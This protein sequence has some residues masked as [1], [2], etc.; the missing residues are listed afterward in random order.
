MRDIADAN[1]IANQDSRIKLPVVKLPTF[2][3]RTEEWKR[4]SETFQSMIH[5][6]ENIP[7]IQKFQYLVTSVSGDAAK[8]IESIEL[9]DQ[10]YT[11]A[12]ELLKRRFDDP[13]AIKKKHIQCLFTMPRIDKE[14]AVAIRGLVDYV[15]KHLRVLKS[16]NLPT[17]SW[18]E[19]VIHMIESKL[20]TT[21]LR[22]WEQHAVIAEVKLATLTDF[23]ERRCQILERLEARTKEKS[24]ATR[25]EPNK[26]RTKAHE[27][28]TTLANVTAAGK[29]YLCHGDHLLYRCEKF[30]ELTVE[31]RIKEVRRLKLCLNC[32]RDDHF[33]KTCK[34]GTCR[35]CS[36][37]HNTLCHQPTIDEKPQAV[38]IVAERTA[39][40]NKDENSSN[41]VVHHAVKE[42]TKR[43]VIMATAVVNATHLNGS[44]VPLR[45]LLDS[46]SEAHFI[47][48]SACN[49]LGLRRERISET[50]TGIGE[51]ESAVSQ[52]C[53]VMI[54]S[55]YSD[56]RVNIRSL[57][58]PKITKF[59]PGVEINRGAFNIPPNIKLADP[60]FYKRG[61]V[62]ML[63]G[64]E[65]F[66]DWLE[67]GKIVL[68]NERLILQ[69]TKLGWIVAGVVADSSTASL[70]DKRA[71]MVA[72]TCS[73]EHCDTLNKTLRRF[74][75]LENC[76]SGTKPQ[77]EE[78]RE[79]D[80]FFER[81]TTRLDNGRFV[82]RLPFRDDPKTLG[83][84]RDI[85]EKRLA[86]LERRFNKNKKFHDRYVE[87][88][89]D[90]LDAGHM[91]PAIGFIQVPERPIVY[92]PHHGVTKETSTTTKLRA[93][94][95]ASS[96]TSSGKSLNDV[97]RVGT[98]SQGSL[99]EILVRF[100]CYNVA[101]IGDIRQMYRQVLV[102]PEDRDFQRILWRFFLDEPVQEF[103]L[104]TVTYGEA[105]SAHLAIRCIQRLAEESEQDF[106]TA[107]RVLREQVYVDDILAG[108]DNIDDAASLQEQLTMI[109]R[110]GGF[111]AHKWCSNRKEAIRKVPPHLKEEAS[112]FRVD[113]DGIIK[114]L[115]LEWN[116][117]DDQF[118]FYMHVETAN[119]KREILSAISKFFDPLGL[120]GPIIIIAKLIMQETWRTRGQ[121]WDEPLSAPLAEKWKAFR[122]DLSAATTI[123][124]PR[125]IIPYN[126]ASQIYLQGF[127]DASQHA[128]GAC[129]YVQAVDRNGT[130]TSRLLCSKSR[131]APIKS[132]S[133]PRLEL[134]SAVLLAHLIDNVQQ[135][136]RVP[137]SGVQAWSDS[138][139]ALYW[140]Y[141]D[142]SRWKPFVANRVTEIVELLPAKHWQHVRGT[143]N[144]ADLISR[145]VTLHQ[146]KDSEIWWSGPSWLREKLPSIVETAPEQEH[147]DQIAE[148]I[149]EEERRRVRT[150]ILANNESSIS[151]EL[152]DKFS[153]LTRVERVL[154]YCLRYLHN[155][156][157]APSERNVSRLSVFELQTAHMS[158]VRDTQ[159][160]KFADEIARIKGN[161]KLKSNSKILQLHPF[162]DDS[163]VLRVGGRLRHSPW[164]FERRHPIILPDG[165]RF[166]RLLFEREH[167]RLLHAG[168]LLLLTSIREKYWPIRGRSL[169][170]KICR[171]CVRCAKINPPRLSQIMGSLPR[172]RVHPGRVFAVTGVDFAGPFITLVNKGRGRK[173]SKSYV[174]LFVCFATKAI[175]LEAVS[176]LTSTAFLATL[177]RFI[178][179]RG[180][181]SLLYS[182]NAT[183]FVGADREMKEVYQFAKAQAERRIGETL[184]N[185]GI[186]WKFIPPHSPHMGGLWEAGI[187]S[188]KHHLKRIMGSA[189]FT[190]EELSTVLIQIEA[191]LNS[192]P[193]SPLSDDPTDLQP[194]TPAHFLVG[195]PMT[196]LPD[197]DVTDVQINRLD[198]WQ[199]VQRTLQDF[200]KR[201]AAEYLSNLQA[202]TKWKREQV[203]LR[204]GDL[205]VLRDENLP[206]LK[207][208]LGRVEGLHLGSDGLIR[209][210]SVR[211]ENGL[212]KRAIAKLCKLP[213]RT[214]E[215][216]KISLPNLV[217][218]MFEPNLSVAADSSVHGKPLGD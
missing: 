106:P 95:D 12:W 102:H 10:N 113:A 174:A 74:W 22:A 183:N 86:Q 123:Y 17:D 24:V 168:Q 163:G 14:S 101:L 121:S 127:C 131:V 94:F 151:Q 136:L 180:R 182:D 125:R 107:S 193:L 20:D 198:R 138:K 124:V 34:M 176:D 178:G 18:D 49:R 53:E 44:I 126:V 218:G 206:P 58:V 201:W 54:R 114:T 156:R 122:R 187:R 119:S 149:Q 29:C 25:V 69:N 64:A 181:P 43:H 216:E 169:A 185:E 190:F 158:L 63:I 191:C 1:N 142:V 139:V 170:R 137:I 55:R 179:R 3:G 42:A 154:A 4:F 120:M 71:A 33:V 199:L 57:V 39:Q 50:I 13:R 159:A 166:T 104:N 210:V 59:M 207:W 70:F 5:S 167:L 161:R 41:V 97:L 171:E 92:L 100:R 27:K 208:K 129:L 164:T 80:E 99:F 165:M 146:L 135:G 108:A 72:L 211:T 109:L 52:G 110:R 133:I 98:T 186:E 214:N 143:D 76:Q 78:A 30:L 40:D 19:L 48:N 204:I 117:S 212:F 65:F 203:N 160:A 11:I 81:T 177:R 62:D 47:T 35:K 23:L 90:Y 85:A 155:L 153:T 9:T 118:Q 197:V 132:T 67:S 60:E 192:R 141:G 205:V 96:K 196:G 73:I 215:T 115:G 36:R 157:K 112:N 89:R 130:L 26:Q 46:A 209:V 175:H 87:F 116:P 32:L 7:S 148:K 188:C 15:L 147:S 31:G 77:S 2:D 217:G 172:D 88:M 37:R 93:V 28:P 79:S 145:G 105:S 38:E 6:N 84:S 202:R 21:T 195:G 103:R 213:V 184:S 75:E 111:E 128:Y 16:M 150:C 162:L 152:I 51:I 66:F 189:L 68:G 61:S 173:T 91:S 83:E 194:L 45:I 8:I 82:V 140:I 56:V 134:C 200:W 144:P